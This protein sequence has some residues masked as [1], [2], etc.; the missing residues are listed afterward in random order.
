MNTHFGL[1]SKI[2]DPL[3]ILNSAIYKNL[4]IQVVR[5]Q[6]ID[7]KEIYPKSLNCYVWGPIK[8]KILILDLYMFLKV[9]SV[10]NY[11]LNEPKLKSL[12]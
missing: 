6:N 2:S 4:H 3:F 9:H 5:C 1:K 11:L 7:Y 8:W 10:S 12:R